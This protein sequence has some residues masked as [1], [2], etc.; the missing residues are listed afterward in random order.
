MKVIDAHIHKGLTE[1]T[2][3]IIDRMES[4]GIYGGCVFSC[5]PK[6]MKMKAYKDFDER[7]DDVIKFTAS[8]KDRLF[9]ILWIH[10]DEENILDKIDI[11]IQ[12]GIDGFKIICNDFYVY[13]E[14]C[15][16]MLRKIAESGK[17]VFFHSGILWDG[18]VSSQFNRPLNWE[19]LLRIKGLK[20][21]MG[22]CSW[23]WH[24]ECLALYGK[25]LNALTSG[26][27]AEMFLDLTPGTPEIYREDLIKKV[28]LTGYDIE[29]NILFGTDCNAEDYNSD[30][31]K[32]WI[33]IDG[34]L[35]RKYKVKRS[36]KENLYYNNLMYFLGKTKREKKYNIPTSDDSQK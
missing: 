16:K 24:D 7:I 11:A 15:L 25:F 8:Y 21:S 14:K 3:N 30:W 33:K 35:M 19:S 22:H 5:P 18:N 1:H 2:E 6:E 4:V 20:F 26:G 23:P 31:A 36:L 27:A 32:K 12:K 13:E 28:F 10:P 9:P 29:E 17:P 34:K